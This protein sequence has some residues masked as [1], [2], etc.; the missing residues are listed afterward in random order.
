VIRNSIYALG[1]LAGIMIG[2]L[3]VACGDD[4]NDNSTPTPSG[5][6][7]PTATLGPTTPPN[8]EA[9]EAA[10]I[11]L[12]E[13]G[14]D[15]VRGE[16]TD[17]ISCT[18]ITDSESEYCLHEAASVFAPGLAILIIG[19]RKDPNERAWE[20]RLVP[21][22]SGWEVTGVTPYGSTE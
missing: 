20:M 16:F 3:T 4:S 7:E 2:T 10:T 19:D 1:G 5:V 21:A 9:I 12:Q 18:S 13:N 11:Y 8:A 22:Q 14:I 6:T 17:P 15:D